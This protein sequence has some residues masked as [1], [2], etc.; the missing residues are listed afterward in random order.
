MVEPPF[1]FTLKKVC[2]NPA[3]VSIHTSTLCSP[4]SLCVIVCVC[5]LVVVCRL[6][7]TVVW[8]ARAA[9]GRVGHASPARRLPRPGFNFCVCVLPRTLA[10]TIFPVWRCFSLACSS[11]QAA[12]PPSAALSYSFKPNMRQLSPCFAPHWF[13]PTSN[14]RPTCP[15]EATVHVRT[16]LWR[17]SD[18][19][20]LG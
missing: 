15:P 14:L 4:L 20:L 2:C 10:R 5:A 18:D 17:T 8:V 16:R 6:C 9:P 7:V 1:I 12:S 13:V 19:F 3:P 11:S